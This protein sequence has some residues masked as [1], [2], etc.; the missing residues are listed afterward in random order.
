M[1]QAP[2]LTE[3][4]W[5]ILK[6]FIKREGFALED[7]KHNPRR[8]QNGVLPWD[9]A[10]EHFYSYPDDIVA[11]L[12]KQ[13]YVDQEEKGSYRSKYSG[14]YVKDIHAVTIPTAGKAC[15]KFVDLGI[16]ERVESKRT[17]KKFQETT[18]Y[19][20]KSDYETFK[21]VLSFLMQHADPYE[22]VEMLSHTYFRRFISEDLVRMRL[23][24]KRV[25]IIS[26]HDIFD[27]APDQIPKILG[28]FT[29]NQKDTLTTF[30][31]KIQTEIQEK[32][33]HPSLFGEDDA[34]EWV[35]SYPF[36][37]QDHIPVFPDGMPITEKLDFLRKEHRS[38]DS[39]TEKYIEALA[40]FPVVLDNHMKIVELEGLILPILALIQSSPSALAEFM[41]GNWERFLF[42][43]GLCSRK[44]ESF[45]CP[46]F[47]QLISL[48]ISDM[49][50]TMQI[51]GNKHIASFEF[52]DFSRKKLIDGNLC[53]ED[54]LL[55]IH[56]TRGYSIYYD[57]GYHTSFQKHPSQI[58]P[59][60]F[61]RRLQP[62]K[63]WVKIKL[64][65]EDSF[66]ISKYTIRDLTKL[67]SG[68]RTT[69]KI[70][71]HIRGKFSHRMQNLLLYY[72]NDNPS[73]AFTTFVVDEI[74][75]ALMREDFYNPIAFSE[76]P[77]SQKTRETI[78]NY[79]RLIEMDDSTG[80]NY[81]SLLHRN[82]FLLDDA[83][84]DALAPFGRIQSDTT[85]PP[86]EDGTQNTCS[87]IT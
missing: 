9:L 70:S 54:A 69:S 49:A 27:W 71:Q 39:D 34:S 55:R 8:K 45:D 20:L 7:F 48:A 58:F 42:P 85:S 86:L 18:Q 43:Q 75:R 46:L 73:L 6:L 23:F 67:L 53:Q 51:P 83:F 33:N 14:C 40:R 82:R 84:P 60:M 62:N 19:F 47:P 65:F 78:D 72:D 41:L 30:K 13:E 63:L 61:E 15:R 4:E 22:R 31:S 66:F 5:T 21:W 2:K 50:S 44:D 80:S 17:E 81:L 3:K 26:R 77:I 28:I 11:H 36:F 74:N 35:I 59:T 24:E 87:R 37:G 29:D 52:R 56:L 38:K 68:L 76:I 32:E 64:R 57:M 10:P 25:S 16:F 79:S 12:T 1:T